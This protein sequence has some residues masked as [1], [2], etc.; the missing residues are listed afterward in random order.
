[1]RSTTQP[2]LADWDFHFCHQFFAV[3]GTRG[4]RNIRKKVRP[5]DPETVRP[6]TAD[7]I[8]MCENQGFFSASP[9]FGVS[10]SRARFSFKIFT[11]GLLPSPS[12]GLSV[13]LATSPRTCSS[14]R[15]A[16]TS[17]I[18]L[19][20]AGSIGVRANYQQPRRCLKTMRTARRDCN[21]PPRSRH[22]TTFT[23]E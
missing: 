14:E 12:R 9:L 2:P 4:K 7:R 23:P 19:G 11:P 16:L 15:R 3:I 21:R 5:A 17:E 10:A 22:R 18:R 6:S 20:W 8:R 13:A 1:M